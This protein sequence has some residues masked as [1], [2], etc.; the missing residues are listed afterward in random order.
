MLIILGISAALL[1]RA[2]KIGE[3]VTKALEAYRV[4]TDGRKKAI[5]LIR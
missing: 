3:L 1:L 5:S 4:R 2:K